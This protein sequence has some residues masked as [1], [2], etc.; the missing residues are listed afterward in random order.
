MSLSSL[1]IILFNSVF[2]LLSLNLVEIAVDIAP[3]V[4][5]EVIIIVGN[6]GNAN[7]PDTAAVTVE[8]DIDII[9]VVP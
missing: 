2:L 9:I 3:T 8:T 5:K 6:N 7:N 1:V 4:D